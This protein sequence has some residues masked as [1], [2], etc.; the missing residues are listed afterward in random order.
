MEGQWE[1][2]GSLSLQGTP[3]HEVQQ[4]LTPAALPTSHTWRVEGFLDIRL[5]S[6]MVCVSGVRKL[7]VWGPSGPAFHGWTA[8]QLTACLR[9]GQ[10]LQALCQRATA[11]C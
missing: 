7:R 11:A 5:L 3:K 6:A 2:D 1:G 8:E 10:F 4:R 9:N